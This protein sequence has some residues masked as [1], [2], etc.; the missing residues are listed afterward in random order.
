MNK[1]ISPV[2][3]QQLMLNSIQKDTYQIIEELFAKY[4]EI[5]NWEEVLMFIIKN[6]VVPQFFYVIKKAQ[7]LDKVPFS[8]I[9]F[10]HRTVEVLKIQK[11]CYEAEMIKIH[12]SFISEG[13][14]YRLVKG[15]A[16]ENLCFDS[17]GLKQISDIDIIVNRND[18]KK[19]IEIYNELGYSSG[20][21]DYQSKQIIRHSREKMLMYKLTGDHLPDYVKIGYD[22]PLI[23]LTIDTTININWEKNKVV[24][25][26]PFN[27]LS[28]I[29]IKDTDIKT[30]GNIPHICYLFLHMYKHGKSLRLQQK[31]LGISF[32][33]LSDIFMFLNRYEQWEDPTLVEEECRRYGLSDEFDWGINY[34]KSIFLSIDSNN[35]ETL[36]SRYPS[37]EN[38]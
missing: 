37:L 17:K 13:I 14:D 38:K 11:E 10:L 33:M 1:K 22:K 6:K 28:N 15:L 24:S 36:I 31:K 8:V 4:S 3:M 34:L 25:L 18:S 30:I 19:I 21:F 12:N 7:V 35:L 32:A 29:K 20:K 27:S 9:E 5:I 16:I 23:P 2:F 26:D